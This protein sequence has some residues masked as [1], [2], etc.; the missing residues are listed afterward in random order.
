[1]SKDD[2]YA[3]LTE[4]KTAPGTGLRSD[5][6]AQAAVLNAAALDGPAQIQ[7]ELCQ[8][9]SLPSSLAFTSVFCRHPSSSHFPF[10]PLDYPLLLGLAQA[11]H[12]FGLKLAARLE[13]WKSK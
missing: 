10:A 12:L 11:V 8:V 13:T 7:C 9:H 4:N 6:A 3:H 2:P 5:E 1:M